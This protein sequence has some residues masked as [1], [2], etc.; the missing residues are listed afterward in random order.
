PPRCGLRCGSVAVLY[1]SPTPSAAPKL[2][3]SRP[4]PVRRHK[5]RHEAEEA[6]DENQG[7]DGGNCH[8]LTWNTSVRISA[9]PISARSG[10]GCSTSRFSRFPSTHVPFVL[11]ST[12]KKRPV[13][14]SRLT[15]ACSRETSSF[16][17]SAR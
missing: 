13:A 11:R 1:P 2:C 4:P 14:P 16:V 3:S 7:G 17:Y 12:I 6:D 9:M 15:W 8:D 10:S 5:Y